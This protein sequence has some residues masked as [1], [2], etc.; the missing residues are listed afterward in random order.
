MNDHNLGET[1]APG[2]ETRIHLCGRLTVRIAGR[3]VEESLPGRQGRMLFAYLASRRL[4]PAPRGELLD[5]LWPE[6]APAAAESALAALLAKLRRVLGAEALAGRQDLR[7]VLPAGAWIDVEAA[8]EGLHAGESANAQGDWA[9]AWGPARVALHIAARSFM[10]GYDAPWIVEA[11][12]RMDDVL[13][14][15]CECVA[16][17]GLGL[18]GPE[19]AAAERSARRLVELAPLRESGYR[20]LM[21]VLA[22][23]DNAAEALLVYE[24]ARQALREA[25]G[26]SPGAAM[27]ALHQ[28]LLT[29]RSAG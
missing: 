1:L 27:Q 10:P 14:R 9:R 8:A 26:T 2:A 16:E 12:R 13:V 17:S 21:R 20:L 29:G 7:L 5:V 24:R 22:A 3:R 6:E 25:L 11:R 15:S 23:Q 19:L 18:G 28:S 4:R